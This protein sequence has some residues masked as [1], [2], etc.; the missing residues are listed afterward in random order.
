MKVK[1]K[2]ILIVSLVGLL[3]LIAGGMWGI[4]Q[5]SW[6]VDVGFKYLE[7][8]N[9]SLIGGMSRAELYQDAMKFIQYLKGGA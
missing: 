5:E 1:L 9:V 8:K 3:C 7:Y 2:N 4:A 6:C